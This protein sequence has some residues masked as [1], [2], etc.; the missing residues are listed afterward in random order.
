M[1]GS[2]ARFLLAK[3][4]SVGSP[5][6]TQL[7]GEIAVL[8]AGRTSDR[9]WPAP[10]TFQGSLPETTFAPPMSVHPDASKLPPSTSL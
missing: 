3:K 5:S 4:R 7:T 10:P 1:P 8:P 6:P 2:G 9:E